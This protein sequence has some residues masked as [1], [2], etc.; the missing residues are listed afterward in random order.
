LLLA[1]ILTVST[2]RIITPHFVGGSSS[3]FSDT[4]WATGFFHAGIWE[5]GANI[6]IKPDTLNLGSQGQWITVYATIDTDDEDNI[7]VSTVILDDAVYAEWWE[8]QDD[9]SFMVKFDRAEVIT[10]LLDEGYVDGDEVELTVLGELDGINFKGSDTI[11]LVR[12]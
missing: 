6:D 9:G 10:Y 2:T 7:D 3:Y 4:E 1:L 12:N 8:V 5:I 11:N